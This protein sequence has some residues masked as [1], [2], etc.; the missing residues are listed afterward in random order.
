MKINGNTVLITGGSTGIGLALAESFLKLENKVIICGRREERLI[1]AQKIHPNL[2]IKECDISS[3]AGRNS[4]YNWVTEN[5]KDLNVLINNAGIQR[6]I[7]FNEGIKGLEGENEIKI[8][9]EGL[10]YL[11]ALFI[12]FLE[13]KEE[14][15]IINI[16]SGLAITP[17]AVF[18]VYC[19]TK[20][21]VH[22]F[23]KCLRYQLSETSIKVFEVL[24]PIVDTELNMEYRDK[25][26]TGNRGIKADKCAAAI[27]DGLAKDDFEILNP[28]LEN[29][30]T[31]TLNDLDKLFENMNGRW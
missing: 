11:S 8:N 6:A 31:S 12:P 28:N 17:L 25:R 5:F 10:V 20:A 4:L 16:S 29:L 13:S 26:G 19:A 1:K 2:Y 9:F 14:S 15:A 21:G 18:P 22:T 7:D 24:P 27:I 23:T 30:K 3:E